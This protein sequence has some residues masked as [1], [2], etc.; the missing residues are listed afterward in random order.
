MLLHQTDGDGACGW[1]PV[2]G[3]MASHGVR[4]IAFD[5]CGYGAAVCPTQAPPPAQQVGAAVDWAR[6]H[7]A[8]RV[9]VVGASMGGSVALGTAGTV[10]PDAVVDLSGPM[11]WDGVLG[12]ARAAHTLRVPLLGAASKGDPD[13]DPAALRAAVLASP[14]THRFVPAPDGHGVEM[15]TSYRNS[16]YVPTALLRTV[17]RW[18]EGDFATA[19]RP[20]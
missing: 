2:A 3:M 12:S 19:R 18:I 13:S 7:G 1:F 17:L 11:E 8:R 16:T 4:V 10:R 15:L 9:T 14:G 20:A 6:A 5:L